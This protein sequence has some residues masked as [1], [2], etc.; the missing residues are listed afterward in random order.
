MIIGL[1]VRSIKIHNKKIL[2]RVSFV[3][4]SF[5]LCGEVYATTMI[6]IYSAA[7]ERDP[8]Y[9][10]LV[11]RQTALKEG[12]PQARAALL[13]SITLSASET[14]IDRELSA[15]GLPFVTQGSA[16]FGSRSYG[17]QLR[18]VVFNY[19]VFQTLSRAKLEFQISEIETLKLKQDLILRVAQQYFDTLEAQDNAE[20]AGANL[21]ALKAQYE[22]LKIL[23]DEGLAAKAD[24]EQ[25][26][27]RWNVATVN[28]IVAINSANDL[29][30]ALESSAGMQIDRLETLND[31]FDIHDFGD[32]LYEEWSDRVDQGNMD[33]LIK[34]LELSIAKKE[35]SIQRAGGYPTINILATFDDQLDDGSLAGAGFNDVRSSFGVELEIPLFSGGLFLSRVRAAKRDLEATNLEHKDMSQQIKR[36]LRT[37]LDS[38]KSQKAILEAYQSAVDSSQVTLKAREEGFK[39]G[40]DTNLNVLDAQRDLFQTSVNANRAQYDALILN[41][42]LERL[43]GALDLE[44]LEKTSKLFSDVQEEI[45]VQD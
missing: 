37:L 5:L 41:L 39:A 28:N 42:E 30:R 7:L 3:L 22:Q 43:A 15:P 45:N 13:P 29:R 20:L 33:I 16:D 24:Y 1:A 32:A 27:A 14:I 12:L 11:L 8:A 31:D 23:F 9:K 6:E 25:A 18:Q 10:A 40:L 35:V 21:K 2:W 34:D 19:E 36:Q 38:L 4:M 26:K 44:D 17:A